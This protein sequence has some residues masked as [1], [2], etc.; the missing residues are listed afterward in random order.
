MFLRPHCVNGGDVRPLTQGFRLTLPPTSA[1]AYAN[2]QLDD[3]QRDSAF[4]FTHRAPMRLS[5]S[6]R[7]SHQD[8]TGT[9]GFG[10]W[11]HPFGQ[12]GDVLAPPCNVWFF[13]ASRHSDMRTVRGVAGWGFKAA[14]LDSAAL[15]GLQNPRLFGLL[16]RLLNPLLRMPALSRPIMASAQAMVRA[17]EVVLDNDW[18]AWHRF[19]MDWLDDVAQFSIDGREVMRTRFVPRGPLGLVIWLDN[20]RATASNGN[21]EFGYVACKEEQWIEVTLEA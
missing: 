11:N 4:A 14:T 6:A 3:Y 21:Y 7:F 16:S 9:S 13:N 18:T 5:L 17:S 1:T 15:P 12:N 2:A 19:E 10:F 8:M 20:Y